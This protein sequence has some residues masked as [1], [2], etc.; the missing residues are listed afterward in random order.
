MTQYDRKLKMYSHSLP[1]KKTIS[2]PEIKWDTKLKK[3]WYCGDVAGQGKDKE[4]GGP[5]L[6]NSKALSV[7]LIEKLSLAL[8]LR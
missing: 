4:G 1:T 2:I 8:P 7:N 6:E 5:L 3:I